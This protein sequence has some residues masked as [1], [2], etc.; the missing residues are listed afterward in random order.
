MG[1]EE[2]G[3]GKKAKRKGVYTRTDVKAAKITVFFQSGTNLN[4]N[5]MHLVKGD[6]N[7]TPRPK[8]RVVGSVLTVDNVKLNY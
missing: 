5:E 8:D 2:E 3:E 6:Y 4:R 1:G 7:A